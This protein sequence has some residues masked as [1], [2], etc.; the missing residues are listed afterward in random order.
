MIPLRVVWDSALQRVELSS[1]RCMLQQQAELLELLELPAHLVAVVVVSDH[2][3]R[4]AKDRRRLIELALGGLL[5]RPV[6][7][8]L[9][10]VGR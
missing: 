9:R 7:V 8:E 2:W 6:V 3:L 10:G 4:L 5:A 1:T